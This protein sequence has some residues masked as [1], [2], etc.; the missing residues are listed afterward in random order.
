MLVFLR[1]QLL[2][3]FKSLIDIHWQYKIILY[4]HLI[5]NHQSFKS[6][7]ESRVKWDDVAEY[8]DVIGW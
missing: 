2:L 1:I 4:D 5:R 6:Y 3:L 8:M 7:E